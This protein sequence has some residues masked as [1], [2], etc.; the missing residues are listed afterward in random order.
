IENKN[1]KQELTQFSNEN[2][3]AICGPN[4][5]GLISLP[6]KYSGYGFFFPDNLKE[7]NVGAVFQSGGLMH[8]IGGELSSR[9]VGM[10]TMISSGNETVTDS[11]EY[12]EYLAKDNNTDV[13][14][15]FIEGIKNPKKFL[16]ATELA[17]KK[18]KPIIAL[19]VGKSKKA[20]DSAI[21]HTGSM[22][23]SNEI[24]NTAFKKNGVIR[25][26][27]IDE[28]IETTV[29]F[30]KY[31]KTDGNQLAITTTSGGESGIYADLGEQL[32]IT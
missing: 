26:D 12:I 22:T 1:K 24:V 19:K 4:C 28:L 23:G 6:N 31:K 17:F 7:G 18:N 32:G 3:F 5:I 9:G 14:V 13:I 8:A 20:E 30:S 16:K 11:S 15:C 2:D 25:V 10:S 21:A 27:D 29:L